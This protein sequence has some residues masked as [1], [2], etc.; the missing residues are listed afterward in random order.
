MSLTAFRVVGWRTFSP[1]EKLPSENNK[2]YPSDEADQKATIG[3]KCQ[4][5]QHET[6]HRSYRNE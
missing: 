5:A 3:S 1:D 6:N 2:G 4:Y